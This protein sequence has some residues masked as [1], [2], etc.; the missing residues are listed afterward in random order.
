MAYEPTT[1]KDGEDGK[2]PITAARLNKIE[3]GIADKAAKG[4]PGKD[5]D[6]G[7]D[8]TSELEALTARVDA[9]EA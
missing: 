2:T 8:L 5:G 7:K 1:W 6:D 3:Q 4:A 9:L